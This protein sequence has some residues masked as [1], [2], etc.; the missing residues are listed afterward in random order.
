[1]VGA[2]L[3][4]TAAAVREQ[5]ARRGQV[6]LQLLHVVGEAVDRMAVA[7]AAMIDEG[8]GEAVDPVRRLADVG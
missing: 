8:A 7:G 1:M 2:Y 4:L 3:G 6:R 5:R